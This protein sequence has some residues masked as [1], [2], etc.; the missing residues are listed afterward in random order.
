M[1]PVWDDEDDDWT[2]GGVSLVQVEEAADETFSFSVVDDETSISLP[3]LSSVVVHRSDTSRLLQENNQVDPQD[4]QADAWDQLSSV[5]LTKKPASVSSPCSSIVILE[6][7]DQVVSAPPTPVA[8]EASSHSTSVSWHVIPDD[9]EDVQ[10]VLT[11]HSH[12]THLSYPRLPTMMIGGRAPSSSHKPPPTQIRWTTSEASVCSGSSRQPAVK[13]TYKQVLK[14]ALEQEQQVQQRLQQKRVETQ[15][16][17]DTLRR[18]TPLL[19][20]IPEDASVV[21]ENEEEDELHQARN[22]Q[23]DD[24][25]SLYKA[26]RRVNRRMKF[27]R[28]RPTGWT[29]C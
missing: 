9:D 3:S 20:Q 22:M 17:E 28:K 12:S 26:R 1:S 25:K 7:G 8:G 6:G 11:W 21:E 4:D 16:R 18:L 10:S 5:V 23:E 2:E 19:H 27:G 14:R 24:L 29:F 15:E 13:L